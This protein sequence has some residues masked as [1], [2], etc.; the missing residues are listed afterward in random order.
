MCLAT[1]I[2]RSKESADFSN[3]IPVVVAVGDMVASVLAESHPLAVPV[4]YE[5]PYRPRRCR[6]LLPNPR[7]RS[8]GGLMMSEL[9]LI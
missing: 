1:R 6:V 3:V 8:R 7:T 2:S 4:L 5:R 9:F